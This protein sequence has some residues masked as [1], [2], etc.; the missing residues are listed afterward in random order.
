MYFGLDGNIYGIQFGIQYL[1]MGLYGLIKNKIT[2][3]AGRKT[4]NPIAERRISM[5]NPRHTIN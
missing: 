5:H 2:P 1:L 3:K 4:K